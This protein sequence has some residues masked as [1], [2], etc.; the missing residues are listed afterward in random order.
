MS[1]V[2]GLRPSVV[3]AQDILRSNDTITALPTDTL[4]ISADSIAVDSLNTDSISK[5]KGGSGLVAV[6]DYSAKDSLVFSMGNMAF[7]FA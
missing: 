2:F 5:K 1:T 7:L 4:L 6:V 3:F